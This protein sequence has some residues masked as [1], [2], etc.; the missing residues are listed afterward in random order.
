M[1]NTLYQVKD[2]YCSSQFFHSASGNFF[3]SIFCPIILLKTIYTL[4]FTYKI[5]QYRDDIGITMFLKTN[6]LLKMQSFYL[7]FILNHL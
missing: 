5:C 1:Y 2:F 6:V 3:I 7:N 4:D